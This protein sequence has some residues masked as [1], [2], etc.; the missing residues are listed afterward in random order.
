MYIF[1]G[2]SCF[3]NNLLLQVN[4][5]NLCFISSFYMVFLCLL[6]ECRANCCDAISQAKLVYLYL[7]LSYPAALTILA[8]HRLG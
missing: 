3:F 4:P 6:P 2:K 8:Q 5:K 7:Y 1:N